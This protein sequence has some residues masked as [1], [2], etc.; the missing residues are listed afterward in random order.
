MAHGRVTGMVMETN[1]FV[2]SGSS[3]WAESNALNWRGLPTVTSATGTTTCR[4]VG[5]GR[6]GLGRPTEI[7]IWLSVMLL[8]L[9]MLV[10]VHG[11]RETRT[12]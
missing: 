6:A 7:Y 11:S 8:G 5:C 2:A 10:L 4:H 1:Y 12:R 9:G 3:E